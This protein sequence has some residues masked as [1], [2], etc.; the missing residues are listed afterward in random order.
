MNSDRWMPLPYGHHKIPDIITLQSFSGHK[1][2]QALM[3]YLHEQDERIDGAMYI[4][5]KA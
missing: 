3:R 1:S 5:E 4:M 2:S